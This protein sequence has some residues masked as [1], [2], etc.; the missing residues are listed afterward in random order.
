MFTGKYIHSIDNKGRL[1]IPAKF[2]EQLGDTFWVTCG[3]DGCL[4]AYDDAE[5][6]LFAKSLSELQMGK[7]D[8]RKIERYF[9]GNAINVEVDKQGRILIPSQLR[10]TASLTKDVV[11]LGLG[12]RIEVWDKDVYEEKNTFDNMDEIAESLEG[13]GVW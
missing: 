7:F 9:L 13:L 6:N 1:I 3:L 5:W 11:L 12:N 8:N 10:D 4:F 2:R